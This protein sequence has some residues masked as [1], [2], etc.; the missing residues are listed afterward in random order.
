MAANE[1][2][3]ESFDDSLARCYA[4]PRFLDRFYERFLEASPEAR[5]KFAN[6]DLA[7]QRRMLKASLVLMMLAAGGKSDGMSHMQ[8]IADVHGKGHHDIPAALYDVW[9]DCLTR[10]A[11]EFDPQFTDELDELWRR[12]LA[13]GIA[14]MKSRHDEP[15]SPS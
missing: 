14:F 6:T 2:D 8:R 11:R 15:P 9:L 10:T 4:S 3:L 7:Q 1:H 5:A 12:V 13:P